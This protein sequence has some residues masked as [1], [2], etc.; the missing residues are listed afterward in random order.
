[1]IRKILLI[2]FLINSALLV[3][4]TEPGKNQTDSKGLKQGFWE[5]KYSNGVLM[6]QGKFKDGKPV[7]Q[8][9]RFY[10]DG[11]PKAV[12]NYSEN[13]DF[14][15]ATLYYQNGAISSFRVYRNEKRDSTWKFYSYYT[16]NLISEEKY[17]NGLKTGFS[18]NYFDNGTISEKTEWKDGKKNG[19]WEQFFEDG[20][21][22]LKS[23]YSN[24]KLSGDLLVYQSKNHLLVKGKYIDNLPDGNWVFYN[25]DGSAADTV[26]YNSGKLVNEDELTKKQQ[27]YFRKIDQNIGKIDEP[28][29]SDFF[30]GSGK[31]QYEY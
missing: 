14:A 10:E 8:M 18:V 27:E 16:K 6:Y 9:K 2:S 30:P 29:P 15:E 4:Q 11:T 23:N 19:L 31:N 12:M 21:L 26:E 3:G 5:K 1:M 24:D 25:E 28:D 17:D 20:S 13:G 22:R 7:G